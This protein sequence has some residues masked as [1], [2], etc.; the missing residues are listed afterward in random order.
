MSAPEFV[1]TN[2]LVYAE[3]ASEPRKRRRAVELFTDLRR[4]ESG[5][6]SIQV[7]QEFFAAVTRKLGVDAVRARRRV[8]LISRLQVVVPDADD[9]LA[10]IDLHRLHGL[11]IWDAMIVRAAQRASCKVLH[12]EDL[13]AGRSYDGLRVVNPFA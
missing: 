2:V 10:A 1:D 9:V 6:V 5:V 3:D 12:T 13:Q 11:S 4:R 7:L 8:E